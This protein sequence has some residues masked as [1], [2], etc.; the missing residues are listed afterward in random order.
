[1]SQIHAMSDDQVNTELRKM[2]AFIRQEAL[3]KAREIHLK[4]DEE[5]SIEK[6]K[7]VRS[8]TARIDEQ[9]KKK[10]TQAGMSQQITKSTL[11]NKTRLR[12]LSA[13]QELLDQLF[14]DANK[15]LGD[16]ASKDKS[17]YEKVL[18]NLILEGLYAL[19][20]EKKVT[21]RCRKKD[22]DVVKKAA[23]GAKEE[24]KKGMKRDIEIHV[25][26][27]ERVAEGSAGGVI[28]LNSTGKIDI[29]NTFEERLHLLE[30]DGLPAV[31]LTLFG[32]NKNRKFKD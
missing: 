14:E 11:A 3:E 16:T 23:E 7:L 22:D 29:N 32:E 9:Y 10:F 2:T 20:N 8:E 24:Y 18:K 26:E 19:V 28:I 6:S 17:K 31:R 21:L 4:A 12:I 1:M 15:K 27:K 30:A 5:F 13:R 25:D